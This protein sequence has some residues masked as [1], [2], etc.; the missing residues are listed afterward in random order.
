MAHVV[1][2]IFDLV[3]ARI[4]LKFDELFS[5]PTLFLRLFEVNRGCASVRLLFVVRLTIFEG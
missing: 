1:V 4:V 3:V 5:I 2:G